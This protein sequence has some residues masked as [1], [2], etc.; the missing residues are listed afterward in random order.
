MK[1]FESIAIGIPDLLLPKTGQDLSKWAV[2]ACDQYTSDEE[3]W[4]KVKDLVGDAPSALN[5]I[6]PEVYLGKE[7]AE[8]RI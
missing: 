5:L 3:Y 2:I 8:T 6:F 4:R 7:D 1:T